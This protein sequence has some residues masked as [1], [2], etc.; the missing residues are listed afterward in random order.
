MK[1]S[2]SRKTIATIPSRGGSK[3][4]PYKSLQKIGDKTLLQLCIEKA[5]KSEA[6][7][8]VFVNTDDEAIANEAL[9]CGAQVPYL[10]KNFGDDYSPVSA[11]TLQFTQDLVEKGIIGGDEYIVQLMPNCPFLEPTTILDFIDDQTLSEEVSLMSAVKVDPIIR[12]A[13]ELNSAGR[14][15]PI[16]TKT[17]IDSR[18]QDYKQLYVPTGAI[19]IAHFSYLEKEKSYYGRDYRFRVISDLEG[20]DIDTQEQLE[21]ARRVATTIQNL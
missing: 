8:S 14:S 18:T 6:F 4:I 1:K 9:A 10:R 11:T 19:W 2:T 17:Q 12:F 3:R 15:M 7:E 5:L 21:T 20:I 13:F 16:I